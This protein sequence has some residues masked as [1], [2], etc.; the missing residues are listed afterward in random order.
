[1]RTMLVALF[2][3]VC[4]GAGVAVAAEDAPPRV[5]VE[6]MERLAAACCD[7]CDGTFG[8]CWDACE[9]EA[10]CQAVCTS[11]LRACRRTCC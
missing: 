10:D 3:G 2:V 8:T 6:Q 7:D 9:G 11:R 1:M 4:C 5:E